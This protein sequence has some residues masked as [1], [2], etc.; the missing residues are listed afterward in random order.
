MTAPCREMENM[1]YSIPMKI[2]L[3]IPLAVVLVLIAG[4]VLLI[5]PDGAPLD[6]PAENNNGIAPP[7]APTGTSGAGNIAPPPTSQQTP[8]PPKIPP[9]VEQKTPKAPTEFTVTAVSSGRI[10]L[11]WK[12]TDAPVVDGFHVTRSTRSD[13][14]DDKFIELISEIDTVPFYFTGYDGTVVP[15]KTYWY[16]MT[17]YNEAGDS[18]ATSPV[19]VTPPALQGE[20]VP[21]PVSVTIS[22]FAYA[23]QHITVPKGTKVTWTNLDSAS[24]TITSDSVAGP[25]SSLLPEG[26]TYSFTFTVPGTYSYHCS[27]HPTMTGS[28]VVTE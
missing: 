27:P 13:F 7:P 3:L 17:A 22:G 19:S 20:N 9:S 28:V 16:R 8:L 11:R 21:N 12:S 5:N 18:P 14:A 4:V 25:T 6:N 15:G 2:K 26:G 10:K 1:L 24:H 23:P